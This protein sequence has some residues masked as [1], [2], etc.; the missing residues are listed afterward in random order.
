MSRACSGTTA[1]AALT[2][3][4]AAS[5]PR[6]AR[7]AAASGASD[8]TLTVVFVLVL[9]AGAYL[10]THYVVERLQRA[11]LVVTGVEYMVLGLLLGDQM[12]Y[13]LPAFQDL[14][15]LFPV[16]ALAVGWVG[17]LRGME[18]DLRRVRGAAPTGATRVAAFQG[19]VS[20]GMIAAAAYA[21][22]SSGRLF[23]VGTGEGQ[24]GTDQV[25]ICSAFLGCVAAAGSV[26]P[27]ELLRTRYRLTQEMGERI[28]RMAVLSD[29]FAIVTFGLLFCV[30]RGDRG[31]A[32]ALRPAEWALVTVLLGAGLGL[33]FTP[34]LGKDDS[35]SG[36]FLALVG[37]IT[38]ANGAAYFLSL[39]PLLVNL[40]LGAVLVNGSRAGRSIRA[41]LDGTKRPMALVLLVCAG[42]LVG[43]E[44]PWPWL[45][46]LAVGYVLLRYIGK[47]VGTRLAAYRGE[48]RPD[49][50]RGLMSHGTVS[51][52]MAVSFQLVYDGPA[53]DL[54][55]AT[56]LVSVVV[57]DLFAPRLL[58]GLLVDSGDL[59]GEAEARPSRG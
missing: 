31:A 20:G 12:P 17:L 26:E 48:L 37:I 52:A 13:A 2:V 11:F 30:F 41:T 19:V 56:V 4:A 55:Y 33:L 42:A 7:A 15:A 49:Y 22:F 18:L 6:V 36:R 29:L 32:D 16:I 3:V 45:P 1:L 40:C 50:Y 9:V 47:V 21:V 59:R 28:R 53:V 44:T 5:Q 35:E 51:V 38:L 24:V 27:I 43:D 34:F 54:A 39:S 14:E 46:Y 10:L 23:P 25:L 57:N 58:R 8:T